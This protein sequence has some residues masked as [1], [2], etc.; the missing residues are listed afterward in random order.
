MRVIRHGALLFTADLKVKEL[1]CRTHD[2]GEIGAQSKEQ[3]EVR[4]RAMTSRR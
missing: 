1:W 2:N 3:R 4:R